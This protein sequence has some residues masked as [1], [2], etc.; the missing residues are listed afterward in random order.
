[1]P[2]HNFRWRIVFLLFL[3]TT[4]NYVDRNVL[5][6]SMLDDA[7]RK[8]MLGVPLSYTLTQ[9]DLDAFKIQY[10]WVDTA[11]KLAYA[12]GFIMIGWLID[13]LGTRKGLSFAIGL[14][15]L[16]GVATAYVGSF[17]RFVGSAFCAWDW[18]SGKFSFEH[19][20]DC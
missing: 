9:A 17:R 4:I 7:F 19:Q 6:F 15:S 5:S 16:A 8:E 3:I 2:P 13:R 12:L 20:V 10:G 1:M 18:R 14:W 11:F